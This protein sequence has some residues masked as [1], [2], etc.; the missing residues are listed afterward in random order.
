MDTWIELGYMPSMARKDQLLVGNLKKGMGR[1]SRGIKRV[2]GLS[3]IGSSELCIHSSRR[4]MSAPMYE[5][6]ADMMF[7]HKSKHVGY[8]TIGSSSISM[9]FS[10]KISD[11]NR[12]GGLV[13]WLMLGDFYI[14]NWRSGV[15]IGVGAWD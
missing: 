12:K 5:Y 13:H 7:W 6:R 8:L 10:F 3:K 11:S 4:E 15:T 14:S 2:I 9:A 1:E